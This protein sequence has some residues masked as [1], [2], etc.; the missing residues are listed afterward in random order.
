[1]SG[2]AQSLLREPPARTALGFGDFTSSH[3]IGN[4]SPAMRR[5]MMAA[6]GSQIKPLVRLN[7][8][9]FGPIATRGISHSEIEAGI[10]VAVCGRCEPVCQCKINPHAGQCFT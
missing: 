2:R 8:I 5:F 4:V 10:R 1:M 9:T 7:K 6:G 3:L